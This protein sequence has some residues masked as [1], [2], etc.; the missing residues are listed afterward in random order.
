LRDVRAEVLPAMASESTLTVNP[1]QALP[2]RRELQGI[3]VMTERVI[4]IQVR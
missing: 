1:L 4:V 2:S 3:Q